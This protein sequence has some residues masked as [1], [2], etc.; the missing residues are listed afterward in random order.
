MQT[1]KRRVLVSVTD[2][3]GLKK[4]RPLVEYG[5]QF[6]STG[7]TAAALRDVGIP[8]TPVEEITG[9]PEM[10][11][12]RVKTLHPHIFGGI[13]AV[14]DN[15]KHMAAILE[16]HIEQIDLVVVNLYNFEKKPDI[17]EI[18]IGGPSLIRAA[19]KNA[20]FTIPVID[21]ND[22]DDVVFLLTSTGQISEFKREELAIKVLERTAA[23]DTM[24]CKW[25]KER[26][27]SGGRFLTPGQ[28]HTP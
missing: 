26:R 1:Q 9:F 5:W 15:A 22:Y 14:R 8:V 17:E 23:Y 16:R 24:I 7:G 27:N 13:L 25:M 10:L 3:S 21:P 11:D 28:P 20:R 6:I 19:A 4:L 18:D 2:K 12:G